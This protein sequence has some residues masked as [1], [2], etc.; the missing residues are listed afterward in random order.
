MYLTIGIG[1]LS[2][3]NRYAAVIRSEVKGLEFT[4]VFKPKIV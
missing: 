2:N 1:L 3:I 4:T